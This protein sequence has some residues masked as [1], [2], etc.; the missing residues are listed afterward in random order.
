MFYRI[1]AF[2]TSVLI[3]ILYSNI[4]YALHRIRGESLISVNRKFREFGV[5]SHCMYDIALILRLYCL[6]V[7]TLENIFRFTSCIIV[8]T[9][10]C[11]VNTKYDITARKVKNWIRFRTWFY[12]RVGAKTFW[13]ARRSRTRS[14]VYFVDVQAVKFVFPGVGRSVP[15]NA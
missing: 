8:G 13:T 11:S 6:C 1:R 15:T 9:D 12:T 4:L 7:F 2:K 10:Y 14:D 3:F 5:M